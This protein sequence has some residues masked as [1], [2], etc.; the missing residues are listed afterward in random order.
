VVAND[1]S[2]LM[3]AGGTIAIGAAAVWRQA[4]Q[5]RRYAR[6]AEGLESP[7]PAVRIAAGTRATTFG[8]SGASRVLLPTIEH[9][10]DAGVRAAVAKAVAHRQWEPGGSARVL[11][12]R[13]W[14]SKELET[15]GYDVSPFGPAFTRISD[16]GGPQRPPLP[17]AVAVEEGAGKS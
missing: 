6:L 1:S 8:L 7:N 13:M 14:A 16:M 2:T 9:D 5:R 10:P 4:T 12:L 11:A 17:T 15:Q 3:V